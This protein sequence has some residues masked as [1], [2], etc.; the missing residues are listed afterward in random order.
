MLEYLL[1][2]LFSATAPTATDL[3]PLLVIFAL[4]LAA[5]GLTRGADLFSMLGV[6]TLLGVSG[7]IGG[8]GAGKGFGSA[9]TRSK[10]K[11]E[12]Q[13]SSKNMAGAIKAGAK[14]AKKA[15][16]N[17]RG[18]AKTKKMQDTIRQANELKRAIEVSKAGQD[19]TKQGTAALPPTDK[20]VNTAVVGGGYVGLKG[21]TLM[22]V[23]AAHRAAD[24][25]GQDRQWL[26]T[27][28]SQ[29][30]QKASLEMKQNGKVSRDTRRAIAE[31]ERALKGSARNVHMLPILRVP[32]PGMSNPGAIAQHEAAKRGALQAEYAAAQEFLKTHKEAVTA[33][34]GTIAQL[35]IA[36]ARARNDVISGY[37]AQTQARSNLPPPPPPPIGATGA[38]QQSY[39]AQQVPQYQNKYANHDGTKDLFN[40][41]D[42]DLQKRV[43]NGAKVF[44]EG[45]LAEAN[46]N[47]AL[48]VQERRLQKSSQLDKLDD[49]KSARA[50]SETP[51]EAKKRE[52][53]QRRTEDYF[54]KEKRR[55]DEARKKAEGA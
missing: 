3:I 41:L 35:R 19:P 40:S 42:A 14:G 55:M 8:G 21:Q 52:E 29:L 18:A 13:K 9:K 37:N 22:N 46:W 11:T 48:D 20:F 23:Q 44:G 49:F 17:K 25:A 24:K 33:L 45:R 53:E 43:E 10:M 4:I 34:S 38:P 39:A 15:V 32:I 51:T 30:K 26:E 6:G 54:A 16:S 1:A 47:R 36:D 2:M 5:A 27:R 7:R 50:D 28:L 31:T 12:M